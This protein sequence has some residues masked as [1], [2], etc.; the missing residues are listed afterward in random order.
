MNSMKRIKSPVERKEF[1]LRLKKVM[2]Q[3]YLVQRAR[4]VK[5]VATEAEVPVE[6]HTVE[7]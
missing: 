1:P 3:V 2:R 4:P 5:E 6:D 7:A